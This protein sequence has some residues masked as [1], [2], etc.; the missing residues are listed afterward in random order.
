MN[1][2]QLRRAVWLRRLRAA[3][4]RRFTLLKNH[5]RLGWLGGH[6]RKGERG[7]KVYFVKQLEVRE[8]ADDGA[9]T[10][11]VPMLRKYTVFNVAQSENLPDIVTA[12]KPMQGRNPDARD[13]L[14]DEFLRSTGA[15]TRRR[16]W[17][18]RVVFGLGS[19]DMAD[20]L[21]LGFPRE[22]KAVPAVR[23]GR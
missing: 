16:E 15:D 9:S 4:L 7:T 17:R 21:S 14:A 5:H 2:S 8:D 20:H 23:P 12:G 13:D 1:L 18:S 10:R 3:C 11:L 6:V 22:A 19:R